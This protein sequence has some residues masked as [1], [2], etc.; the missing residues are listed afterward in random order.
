MNR[1]K[2]ILGVGLLGSLAWSAWLFTGVGNDENA[3]IVQAAVRPP[4]APGR[5]TA[6]AP[7]VALGSPASA[8][9]SDEPVRRPGPPARPRNLFGEY[10]FEPPKPKAPPPERPHAPALPFSYSGRLVIDGQTT[11]LLAR[12]DA[13]L[14][15]LVVGAS[16]GDFQLV[17]ADAQ[18]LVFL[19]GP[20]GDR[21]PLR[22]AT[23][24]AH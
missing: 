21:V 5:P 11:Y 15:N 4:G 12:G 1:R 19:H 3:E 18:Q 17:G 2:L 20:T 16:A 8:L 9:T 14:M 13:P 22:F 6:G 23:A 10:S 24:K 7:V